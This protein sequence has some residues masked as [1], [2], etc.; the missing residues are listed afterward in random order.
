MTRNARLALAACLRYCPAENTGVTKLSGRYE[1]RTS[2]LCRK[3]TKSARP[4]TNSTSSMPFTRLPP[5][6]R[7]FSR[8]SFAIQLKSQDGPEKS[9]LA[10]LRL[11]LP[12]PR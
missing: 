2:A 3:P 11:S 10:S 12:V 8:A 9:R 5:M 7:S 4:R 6:S 1:T